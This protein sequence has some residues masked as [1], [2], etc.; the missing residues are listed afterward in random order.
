MSMTSFIL[1]ALVAVVFGLIYFCNRFF[2]NK[3]IICTQWILLLSSYLFVIYADFRFALVLFAVSLS[4]W[5]FAKQEKWTFMGILLPL[6]ALSYFKYT[7]FFIES[8]ANIFNFDCRTLDIILPIGMSFFTFSA[9][10]YVVD[11]QKGKVA[12]RNFRDVSLYLAFFPKLVSGPIQRSGDFFEQMD[13]KREIGWISFSS[14]VQIFV[15]GLFKKIV[16]ADRLS[17]FVNQ[18]YD[19]PNA[20]GSATVLLAVFAYSLQIYLDFS[21]YSDMAIGIAKILGFNLP[22]NFNLPYLSHNVT[23]LW[24]RWHIS[25]SSWLLDYST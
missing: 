11:V 3:S 14:G 20:F 19:T 8:F 13:Q 1:F 5:F 6:L 18:V 22:R 24:K 21:G 17:V 2:E 23:E 25:L 4:T 7:N 12:S 10:S 15:F 16:L 9:I